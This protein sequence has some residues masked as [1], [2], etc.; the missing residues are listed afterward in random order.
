[1]SATPPIANPVSRFLG[2]AD[3]ARSIQ[4]YRDVLGFAISERDEAVEA[5]LGP[6]RLTL[7][8]DDYPPNDFERPRTRGSA[9]VFFHTDD[10]DAWHASLTARNA[11]PCEVAELNWLKLRVF[12]VVDPDG[13]TLW[14]GTSYAEPVQVPP[15]PQ[16]RK[17]LPELPCRDVGASVAHFRDVLG[18]SINYQQEDLGVMDRDEITILL[19]T[20]TPEHQGIGSFEVYVEN[21]DAL[22]EELLAK[23]AD[24]KGRPVSHPWGLR[25][26]EVRD[27]D[28]NRILFA[29][30]FE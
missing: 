11:K 26:F 21:A 18:F 17:A 22:Y 1:M 28:Q 27:P 10:L 24:V 3:R 13:H 7:G 30:T 6:A 25:T 29:Q 9:M 20:R 8:K 15:A 23:G 12:S 14:F 16:L 4:F 2:V 19:V 5:T